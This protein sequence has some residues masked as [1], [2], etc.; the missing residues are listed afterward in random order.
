M[1]FT[2]EDKREPDVDDAELINSNLTE[3]SFLQK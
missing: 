2:S 1:T 3:I